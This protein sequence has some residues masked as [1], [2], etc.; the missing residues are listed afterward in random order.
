MYSVHPI[1]SVCVYLP[2]HKIFDHAGELE[3]VILYR[4]RIDKMQHFVRQQ[5]VSGL[6][7]KLQA[8]WNVKSIPA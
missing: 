4:R 8:S 7:N 3:N 2:L 1:I 5:R 6:K